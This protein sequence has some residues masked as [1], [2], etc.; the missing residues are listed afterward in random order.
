MNPVDVYTTVLLLV[1]TI[2]IK[3]FTFTPKIIH[4]LL[5]DLKRD[6]TDEQKPVRKAGAKGPE[7]HWVL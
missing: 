1:G 3:A 7:E 6:R 5:D 4:I 2:K